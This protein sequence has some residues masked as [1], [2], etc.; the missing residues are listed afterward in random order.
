VFSLLKIA[1]EFN[2]EGK[3]VNKLVFIIS[4]LM[5]TAMVQCYSATGDGKGVHDGSSGDG[6]DVVR[7]LMVESGI[8]CFVLHIC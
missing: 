6:A 8:N 5:H 2:L 1:D 4:T 7:K 3:K